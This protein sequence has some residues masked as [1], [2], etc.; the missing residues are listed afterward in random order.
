MIV[1]IFY[2]LSLDKLLI[3]F[4]PLKYFRLYLTFFAALDKVPPYSVFVLFTRFPASHK[5]DIRPNIKQYHTYSIFM[6]VLDLDE[7]RTVSL[8]RSSCLSVT[9]NLSVYVTV[10]LASLCPSS[11]PSV[12][13]STVSLSICLSVRDK[14]RQARAS[15]IAPLPHPPAAT[16]PPASS[17]EARLNNKVARLIHL[18]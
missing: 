8:F 3:R 1:I 9:A 18:K 4:Q 10:L 2:Y 15:L 13:P 16:H 14:D 12:P 6:S 11:R 17:A 5:G 7:F